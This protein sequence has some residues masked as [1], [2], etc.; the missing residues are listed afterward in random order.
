MQ[1]CLL[2]R[3]EV[4]RRLVLHYF[5]LVQQHHQPL[6]AEEVLGCKRPGRLELES[7]H[8]GVEPVFQTV[9]RHIEGLRAEELVRCDVLPD[10]SRTVW[11][12][13]VKLIEVFLSAVP[14]PNVENFS[15]L[16]TACYRVIQSKLELA[17]DEIRDGLVVC[18]ICQAADADCE[19]KLVP[20][21]L[22][23]V[24]RLEVVFNCVLAD[25]LD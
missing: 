24:V 7:Q 21:L 13:L 1:V 25:E 15:V 6:V 4:L 9:E 17:E 3:V 16:W 8:L 10:Q 12:K 5:D 23:F 2:D 22:D 18:E 14:E 20:L 11:I 19:E